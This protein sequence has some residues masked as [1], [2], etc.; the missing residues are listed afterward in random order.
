MTENDNKDIS[1]K[2]DKTI[3]EVDRDKLEKKFSKLKK[4]KLN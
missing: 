3:A 1:E 4:E 2:K